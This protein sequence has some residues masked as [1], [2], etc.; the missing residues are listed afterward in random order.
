MTEIDPTTT[1]RAFD[2][3]LAREGLSFSA[4]VIGGAALH[5]LGHISRTTDDVDVLVPE[6]PQAIAEAAGRFAALG[7]SQ[8]TDKGWFNSKSYDFVGVPG[9]LPVGWEER[10]RPLLRGKALDLRTLGRHD[11]LCTKLAALVDREE[12]LDD[13]IAMAPTAAELKAAW[14]FLEQYEGNA[15]VRRVYWIPK[16]R[17]ALAEIAEALGHGD[18]NGRA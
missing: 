3:F 16:A 7:D 15:E 6:V 4:V 14:P 17:A 18:D 5:A 8:P 12:D 9:C 10:L 11:L 2:E 1:L 13:C